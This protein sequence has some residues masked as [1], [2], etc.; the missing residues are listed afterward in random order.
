LTMVLMIGLL[1]YAV[2]GIFWATLESCK[3]PDKVKG[4]AIGMISLIGYSPD[5]YLP[6]LR[7]YLVDGYGRPGYTIYFGAI[8]LIGVLGALAA[9]RLKVVVNS[10]NR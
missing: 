2:R 9:W 8:A 5:I 6:R 7:G 10:R 4:L 3:V 1:T